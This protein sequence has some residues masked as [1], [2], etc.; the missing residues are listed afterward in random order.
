MSVR[1]YVCVCVCV[2]MIFIFS[3]TPPSS[4]QLL[5]IVLE[6]SPIHCDCN[7]YICLYVHVSCSLSALFLWL[8]APLLLTPPVAWAVDTLSSGRVLIVLLAAKRG[9]VHFF[10]PNECKKTGVLPLNSL[11]PLLTVLNRYDTSFPNILLFYHVILIRS[12]GWFSCTCI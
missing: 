2:N 4:S 9:N 5:W 10:D 12:S 11:S 7:I 8:V 1:V 6:G 3:T